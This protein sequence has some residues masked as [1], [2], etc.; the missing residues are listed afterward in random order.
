MMT[1]ENAD[2][3]GVSL[4]RGFSVLSVTSWG[5][6]VLY[7]VYIQDSSV[8]FIP[9]GKQGVDGTFSF[10]ILSLAS[11]FLMHRQSKDKHEAKKNAVSFDGK[12]PE[13]LLV[14][15]GSFKLTRDQF[16][17]CPIEPPGLPRG[18]SDLHAFRWFF[19]TPK[20]KKFEMRIEQV[21]DA[22]SLLHELQTQLGEQL[23]VN[24]KWDSQYHKFGKSK[25]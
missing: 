11:I 7:R 20:G 12:T 3:T 23:N 14:N 13:E 15:P 22:K 19:R 24:V 10:G 16:A 1:Q 4:P 21:S 2:I 8:Y 18:L 17:D 5:A 6:D 9:I 25:K